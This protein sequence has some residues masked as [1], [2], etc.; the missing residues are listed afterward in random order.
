M[1]SVRVASPMAW[2]PRGVRSSRQCGR[3]RGSDT[4]VLS[5]LR[6][7]LGWVEASEAEAISLRLGAFLGALP[8]SQALP[9]VP[10]VEVA[11]ELRWGVR[12]YLEGR[13]AALPVVLVLEDL[14]WAGIDL[15]DTLEYLLRWSRA[16]MLVLA[17]AR[18]E[19]LDARPG[20]GAE[21]AR[22][23]TI[24]LE[25][26]G[27]DETVDLVSG[28]LGAAP[29]APLGQEL[30]AR[31]EGNP[32]F[33]EEFVRMLMERGLL[34]RAGSAW[35]AEV[36]GNVAD[37]PPTIHGIIA[38][39]IDRLPPT[40]KA[41]VGVASVIGREFSLRALGA[42]TSDLTLPIDEASEAL[43]YGMFR[44]SEERS[45]DG[46][47]AFIFKHALIRDVAYAS[48]SKA[49]RAR[50][51]ERY[52][53][54]LEGLDTS[55]QREVRES[56][57]QHLERSAL[58]ARATADPRAR[59]IGHRAFA[60]L[61]RSAE[62]AAR[63][64]ALPSALRLYR[65]ARGLAGDIDLTSSDRTVVDGWVAHFAS[66]VEGK[67]EVDIESVIARAR[68]SGPSELLARLLLDRAHELVPSEDARG[69][70]DEAIATARSVG[71]AEL[72]ADALFASS[73]LAQARLRLVT[74]QLERRDKADPRQRVR[75]VP[76]L[77]MPKAQIAVDAA[78]TRD[79]VAVVAADEGRP[80]ERAEVRLDGVEPAG[81]GRGEDEADA[82]PPA[83]P[84]EARV[85]VHLPQVVEDDVERLARVARA[86]P[87][88]GAGDLAHA[89]ALLEDAAEDVGVDVVEAEERL[90]AQRPA[91]GRAHPHRVSAARPAHA[92]EGPELE[93]AELVE[94]DDRRALRAALVEG[95][96]ARAFGPKSGSS[97]C[98]QVRM[99]WGVRP[100]LRSSRRTHSSVKSGMRSCSLQYSVRRLTVQT[101]KGSPSSSGSE[102]AVM[103]RRRTWSPLMIG[104]LPIGLGT[105]SKVEKPLSLKRPTQR[106]AVLRV[107]PTRSAAARAEQP[108]RTA[109]IT[110][111]RWC[112]WAERPRLRSFSRSSFC[113]ARVR[114]RSVALT[115]AFLLRSPAERRVC[116]DGAKIKLGQH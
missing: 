55:A 101:V 94:A 36:S 29:P 107:T 17:L 54:Y 5:K 103:M 15:L 25:P 77:A 8:V 69:Y 40:V 104:I 95:A 4:V 66:L 74:I 38:A 116:A 10:S 87:A 34:R 39:R 44:A 26:L 46:G 53:S 11:D 32:L 31:T 1:C 14:H 97:E 57:A 19:L 27:K 73:S 102:S 24:E 16:P 60:Q 2:G 105:R 79:M 35:T 23:R 81:L 22:A 61:M 21:S 92:S 71:S 72:I 99:R 12:R 86:Q 30:A 80:L 56:I 82:H 112:T 13:A 91:V 106:R 52:A 47:A 33:V 110:R 20:W 18:P 76:E 45:I 83:D 78:A 88:E 113:S 109:A 50:T 6:T 58:F 49:E 63:E 84:Q 65:I 96:D 115:T 3:M 51:H 37:L 48:V 75:G 100:S 41:T 114:G 9:D 64:F 70:F 42:L 111:Y 59:E 85:V 28:L 89:L 68:E 90:G 62:A 93:R 7:A 43:R 67:P 108:E 98:F